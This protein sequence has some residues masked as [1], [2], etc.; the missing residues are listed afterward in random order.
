MNY[1]PILE[2]SEY[3]ELNTC[4]NT[5]ELIGV[6]THLGVS[7]PGGHF[8]AF[9]KSPIDEKWYKYNDDKVS[10]ADKFNI[11]NEGVAYILFYRHTKYK[12]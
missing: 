6:I 8:I 10:E 1:P 4:P 5:Y 11:Y 2:L 12:K 9:C 3:I 7:G